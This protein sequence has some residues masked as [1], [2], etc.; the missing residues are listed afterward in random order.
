MHEILSVVIYACQSVC[1]PC[2]NG[3]VDRSPVCGGDSWGLKAHVLG[4]GPDLPM[5]KL[6]FCWVL[7]SYV[8]SRTD[9]LPHWCNIAYN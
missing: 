4:K 8:T 5:A 1:L 9:M 2:K 6:L 3:S 7:L